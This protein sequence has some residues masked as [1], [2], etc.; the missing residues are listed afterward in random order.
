MSGSADPRHRAIYLGHYFGSS[1]QVQCG[2]WMLLLV[3]VAMNGPAAGCAVNADPAA[4]AQECLAKDL[5]PP[6]QDV[7][8]CDPVGVLTAV[9]GV[10]F[11][12]ATYGGPTQAFHTAGPLIEPEYA[13]ATGAAAPLWAPAASDDAQIVS[14]R[15]AADD[16]P[17]DTSTN[18]Q[19]TVVVAIR[20]ADGLDSTEL[21]VQAEASRDTPAAGWQLSRLR[22]AS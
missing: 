20:R 6:F 15:V 8:A 2:R 21:V 11:D 4:G 16:H 18:A 22:V 3:L 13:A 12:Y 10:A 9:V 19:R 7:D 14:V 5:G 17:A 1:P